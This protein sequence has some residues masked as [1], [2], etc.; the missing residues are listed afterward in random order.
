LVSEVPDGILQQMAVYFRSLEILY[1][2][3]K[4]DIA[5][6]WTETSNLMF[7]DNAT[8][9]NYLQSVLNT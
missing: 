4:V 7:L 3:K 1:P 6:L 5:I 8:L 9:R 2:E